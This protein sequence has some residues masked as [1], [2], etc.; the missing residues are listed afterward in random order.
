MV[1]QERDETAA[2][3]RAGTVL[4]APL[5]VVVAMTVASA[6]SVPY[7]K[8]ETVTFAPPRAVMVP[9]RVAALP[10]TEEADCVVTVGGEQAEVVK[11]SMVP[12]PVPAELV[13]YGLK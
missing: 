2:E 4:V 3:I 9:F 1:P 7:A 12:R 5:P 10:S 11:V 6:E 8:P 13:A